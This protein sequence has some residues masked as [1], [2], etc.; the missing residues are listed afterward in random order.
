MNVMDEDNRHNPTLDPTEDYSFWYTEYRHRHLAAFQMKVDRHVYT[1][2]G[3]LQRIDVFD[4]LQFGRV[5]T[6]DGLVMVTEKDE[7]MYHEMLVHVPMFVHPDPKRVLIVGGGDGGSLREV[8]RHPGVDEAVLVEIDG[9]VVET[10]KKYLPFTSSAM[11]D[12][13]ATIIIEEGGAFIKA[14]PSSF[15]VIIIDSTDPTKGAGGLLFTGEFYASCKRALKPGGVVSAE[16]EDVFY[17]LPFWKMA[18]ERV[19][20]AFSTVRVYWGMM[21]SY[22]SGTWTYTFAGDDRDPLAF[23]ESDARSMEREL[24][25]YNADIHRSAFTLPSFLRDM[26]RAARG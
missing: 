16:T 19:S 9:H 23:R 7:W 11:S 4:T 1:H 5:M 12:P 10:A 15:D 17:D 13:R 3:G 26:V 18:V 24:R 8:L 21:T 6:L 2:V 20:G 14:N 25:Y 22:P